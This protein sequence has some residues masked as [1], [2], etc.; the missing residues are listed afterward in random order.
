MALIYDA[1]ARLDVTWHLDSGA[2][3]VVCVRLGEAGA[4]DLFDER[5][6]NGQGLVHAVME[7]ARGWAEQTLADQPAL[8]FDD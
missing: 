6:T 5:T 7:V 4:G 8:P 1:S 3:H 2:V